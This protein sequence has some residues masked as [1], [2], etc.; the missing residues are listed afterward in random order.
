[1]L[2]DI[3]RHTKTTFNFFL[4]FLIGSYS[5]LYEPREIPIGVQTKPL[6]QLFRQISCSIMYTL[7]DITFFGGRGRGYVV[8]YSKCRSI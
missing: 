7:G 8:V 1:M 2:D 4:S 3:Y 5:Q 6:V